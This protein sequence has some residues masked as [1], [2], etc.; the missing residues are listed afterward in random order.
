MKR[1]TSAEIG[2][3][4]SHM[5]MTL[6]SLLSPV[7]VVE[8]DTDLRETLRDL[9]E[10]DGYAVLE[11]GNPNEALA[12]LCA[13]PTSVVLIV[14]NA[15]WSG[16][17]ELT[18]FTAIAAAPV[19]AAQHVYIYLTTT[20]ERTLPVLIAILERLGAPILA[21]PFEIRTWED[22]VAAAATTLVLTSTPQPE[23]QPEGQ[24]RWLARTRG[25]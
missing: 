24:E 13:L 8:A 17:R 16:R 6:D 12:L 3:S 10:D 18:F 15:E 21:K 23:A 9:L 19:L 11:A 2:Q 5:T 25:P 22:T 1:L 4:G 14:S 7:F 20:P